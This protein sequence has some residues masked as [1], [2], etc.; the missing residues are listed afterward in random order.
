MRI[1]AVPT[2]GVVGWV[3]TCANEIEAV[4]VINIRISGTRPIVAIVAHG[5]QGA[6]IQVDIPA[7]R[8]DDYLTYGEANL[9]SVVVGWVGSRAIEMEVV[10][11]INIKISGTRP[12]EASESHVPQGASIQADIPATKIL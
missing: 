2:S 11:V 6:S 5:P 8:L 10:R 1:E 3:G 4:R 9:A 7:T 12:I